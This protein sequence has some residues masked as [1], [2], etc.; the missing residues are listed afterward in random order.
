MFA[1]RA[2]QLPR[3][4]RTHTRREALELRGALTHCSTMP[5]SHARGVEWSPPSPWLP[6]SL[7][8]AA[9]A[10]VPVIVITTTAAD[11]KAIRR[12]RACWRGGG[13]NNC[14]LFSMKCLTLNQFQCLKYLMTFQSDFCRTQPL[15]HTRIRTNF[16]LLEVFCLESE[17]GRPSRFWRKRRKIPEKS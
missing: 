5:R 6:S 12:N 15:D 4:A 9:A 11:C 3:P 17:S 1:G 8:D 2:Q 16:K 10:A 13:C 7:G 14:N